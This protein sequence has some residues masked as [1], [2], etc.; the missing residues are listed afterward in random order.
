MRDCIDF[1]GTESR[2]PAILIVDDEP[3]ICEMLARLF[4]E[5]GYS[6]TT[7]VSGEGVVKRV[8]DGE[9]DI[10]LLDIIMSQPDGIDVLRQI[11]SIRSDLPVVMMTAFGDPTTAKYAMRLGAYDYISKPFEFECI[12]KIIQ[13][14]LGKFF[15]ESMAVTQKRK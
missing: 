6:T 14:G 10:V 1:M 2:K 5:E 7:V 15:L 9:V 4:S 11:K 12:K 13:Q 3:D 8:L